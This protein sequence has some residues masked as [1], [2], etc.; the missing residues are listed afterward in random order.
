MSIPQPADNDKFGF[1]PINK[2]VET[3][4]KVVELRQQKQE[5]TAYYVSC[6]L[7]AEA[8]NY[9]LKPKPY[10]LSHKQVL[11]LLGI[12]IEAKEFDDDDNGLE[13]VTFLEKQKT[14]KIQDFS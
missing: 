13:L 3:S 4:N 11:R 8:I 14:K 2:Q 5:S 6:L 10:P 12:K 9:W 1:I 7:A